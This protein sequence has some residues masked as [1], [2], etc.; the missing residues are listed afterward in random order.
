MI[1]DN[2]SDAYL[3]MLRETLD[4]HELVQVAEVRHPVVDGKPHEKDS[5]RKAFEGFAFPDGRNGAWWIQNRIDALFQTSGEYWSAMRR[6]GQWDYIMRALKKMRDKSL[7]LWNANRLIATLFDPSKDLHESRGPTPPC[8]IT[9][10]LYPKGPDLSL[11]A[12]F[13][14]QYTDAKAYGNLISLAMLLA[15]VC[16]ETGFRPSG[17]Y[18]IAQKATLKYSKPTAHALYYALLKGS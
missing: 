6:N 3:K 5:F 7:P 17:L 13:R 10:S 14:A 9:L 2:I 8:M 12:V 15:Q 1:A 16:S 18:N 11:S 4:G